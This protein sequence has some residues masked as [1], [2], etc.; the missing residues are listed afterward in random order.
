TLS[1][2]LDP[3]LESLEA[4]PD[5][6]MGKEM[7]E[8]LGKFTRL[9]RLNQTE[10]KIVHYLICAKSEPLLQDTHRVLREVMGAD[11]PRYF[12][13]VLG[14]RRDATRRAL[15]YTGPLFRSGV[16][17]PGDRLGSCPE[18][19]SRTVAHQLLNEPFD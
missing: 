18:F 10:S 11:P 2:R 14:L 17:M 8:N 1:K 6:G 16:L 12:I 4:Q 7:A 19:F 9:L 3:L 13:K 5:K 15:S